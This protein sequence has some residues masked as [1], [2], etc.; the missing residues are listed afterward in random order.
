[1]HPF[2]NVTLFFDLYI[3]LYSLFLHHVCFVREFVSV[4]V[5]S[6]SLL[7]LALNFL[8]F[9]LIGMIQARQVNF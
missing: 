3:Y 2:N 7:V 5:L 8:F 9:F 1:M 6:F 4:C